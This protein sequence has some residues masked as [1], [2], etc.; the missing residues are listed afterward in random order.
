MSNDIEPA[1]P[2]DV[3]RGPHDALRAGDMDGGR[4]RPNRR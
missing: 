2:A 4:A 1:G 3:V